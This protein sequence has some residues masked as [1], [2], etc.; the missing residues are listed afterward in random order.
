MGAEELLKS[1]CGLPGVVVGDLGGDVVG[2]V[3]LTDTVEDVR[4]DWSEEVSVNGGERST[5]E[6][7][8]VGGVVG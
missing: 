1:L 7:P 2:D 6:G 3:G 4:A 5:G 8:L